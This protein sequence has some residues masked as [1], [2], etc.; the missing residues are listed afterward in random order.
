MIMSKFANVEKFKL[1]MT[2]SPYLVVKRSSPMDGNVKL[3][4]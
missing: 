2:N 4:G 1:S 3:S